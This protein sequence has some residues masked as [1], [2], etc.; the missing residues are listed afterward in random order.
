MTAVAEPEIS[1]QAELYGEATHEEIDRQTDHLSALLL[2]RPDRG[3]RKSRTGE[4]SWPFR[5]SRLT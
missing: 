4:T 2:N 3:R 1:F 5:P